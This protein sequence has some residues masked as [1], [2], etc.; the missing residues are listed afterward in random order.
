MP[1]SIDDPVYRWLRL[2]GLVGLASVGYLLILGPLLSTMLGP[3]PGAASA[4]GTATNRGVTESPPTLWESL[5]PWLAFGLPLLA[6]VVH[7]WRG[8]ALRP[9]GVFLFAQVCVSLVAVTVVVL[10]GAF[11][12]AVAA[13]A[14]YLLPL[15]AVVYDRDR[16]AANG[17]GTDLSVEGT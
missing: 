15:V 6:G 12:G 2:L 16:R 14:S 1:S 5:A 9:L 11:P 4:V 10:T 8:Y 13:V 3:G 7:V 17:D